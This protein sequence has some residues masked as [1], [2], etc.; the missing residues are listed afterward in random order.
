MNDLLA[1]AKQPS[2]GQTKTRLSPP[3]SL[4]AAA[5]LY[6]AFMRDTLDLLPTVPCAQPGLLYWPDTARGYFQALAPRLFLLPQDGDGLGA[7]LDNALTHCLTQ[8]GAGKAVI[9]DTDSPTLPAAHLTQAFALLDTADV[10]L[11]PCD[12]GGYYLIGLT[13]PAPRLL[14]EVTM[15]T[16]R[17]VEETLALAATEGLAAALLPVWYDVDTVAELERLRQDLARLPLH[18]APHTRQ[19]LARLLPSPLAPVETGLSRA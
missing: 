4:P 12:D 2:P 16:P 13:R 17:V 1:I 18:R 15:S 10:V 5:E 14:R 7:R 19:A 11:G 8:R 3:L 6:E 9:V